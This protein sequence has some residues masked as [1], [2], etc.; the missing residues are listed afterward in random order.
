MKF[1]SLLDDEK[2]QLLVEPHCIYC[3]SIERL[4]IDHLIPRL[5]GGTHCQHNLVRACRSC[6]SSKGALDLLEWYARGGTFPP[7][8]LLRRYLKIV[9]T[10]C[11]AAG[12][13]DRPFDT[14]A[15]TCLPFNLR[16]LPMTFPPLTELRM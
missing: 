2:L 5:V 10:H 7:L 9:A 12:I 13:M 1:G 3:G 4:T 16:R 15:D 8:M 11:E 14:L 6:N